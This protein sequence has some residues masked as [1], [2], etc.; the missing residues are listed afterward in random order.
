MRTYVLGGKGFVGS[1]FARVAREQGHEVTIVTRQ[2]YRRY[3]GTR[4]DWL[5]N[6]N[7]NSRKFLADANP[8]AEFDA[9]VASVLRSLLDFSCKRYVLLS[10]IDVYPQVNAPRRN[11]EK[12]AIQPEQLSRYGLHKWL[13]EQL[14][15]RYAPRWL[16]IRLGG[17]VGE[18]L[19]KNPI[20]DILHSQP[21]RVHVDST[22]QYLNTDEVARIVLALVRQ[23]PSNDVF[24]VCG[25]GL[26]SLRE[27]ASMVPGWRL[28]YANDK[29][30]KE[31]YEVNTAK[32]RSW[33][34]VPSTRSTVQQYVRQQLL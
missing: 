2:N 9:S 24:N 6:A 15:R 26:I 29:P 16:V 32:L 23:Q 28:R 21:L 13:A 11:H 31:H 22:Y 19:W 1:A 14:V 27:V 5:I 25:Y 4:C 33:M 30:R 10:T 8:A 18:G 17:M 7:G 20:F 12:A 34:P 3:R